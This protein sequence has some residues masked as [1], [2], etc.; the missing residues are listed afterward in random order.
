VARGA[1]TAMLMAAAAEA[2][3]TLVAAARRTVWAYGEAALADA[4]RRHEGKAPIVV[5]FDCSAAAKRALD[6]GRRLVAT[7]ERLLTVILTLPTRQAGN[8]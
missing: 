4:G 1:V 2:D 6:V 3:I 8:A 7:E 5:V